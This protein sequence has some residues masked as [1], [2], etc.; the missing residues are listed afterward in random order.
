[1]PSE[2][3]TLLWV[4]LEIGGLIVSLGK[5][6]IHALRYTATPM[7]MVNPPGGSG[8]Y[9]FNSNSD[10]QAMFILLLHVN[11]NYRKSTAQFQALV[12]S[13]N[14]KPTSFITHLVQP[15]QGRTTFSERAH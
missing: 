2:A 9:N 11:K 10:R 3:L 6:M 8:L 7:A 4:S 1:M 12:F 5:A 13:T 15:N 14:Q